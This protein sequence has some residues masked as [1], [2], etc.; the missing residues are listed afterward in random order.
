MLIVKTFFCEPGCLSRQVLCGCVIKAFTEI[1][2]FGKIVSCNDIWINIFVWFLLAFIKNIAFMG[3]ASLSD[4]MLVKSGSHCIQIV[5]LFFLSL[6]CLGWSRG[7]IMPFDIQDFGHD[8]II[9]SHLFPLCPFFRR[10]YCSVHLAYFLSHF[11]SL[12]HTSRDSF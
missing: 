11:L 12:F 5:F 3:L 10:I 7:E 2:L 9:F 1:T 4:E 8:A 6:I